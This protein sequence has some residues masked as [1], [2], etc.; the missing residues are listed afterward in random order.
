MYVAYMHWWRDDKG[1]R[2]SKVI[3]IMR[4]TRHT[5]FII[6]ACIPRTLLFPYTLSLQLKCISST[7]LSPTTFLVSSVEFLNRA[8][9]QLGSRMEWIC[10]TIFTNHFKQPLMHGLSHMVFEVTYCLFRTA[11]LLS[12]FVI[13]TCHIWLSYAT[14]L[15]SL[16][17]TLKETHKRLFPVLSM[18]VFS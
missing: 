16:W 3:I 13:G 11:L 18:Q 14:W 5:N 15:L 12:F 17:D 7:F 1:R 2:N 8:P 6:Y 9:H 4:A 10:M